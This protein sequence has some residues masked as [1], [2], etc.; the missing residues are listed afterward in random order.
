MK[1]P[2]YQNK[3]IMIKSIIVKCFDG[4]EINYQCNHDGLFYDSDDSINKLSTR[5]ILPPQSEPYYNKVHVNDLLNEF[6]FFRS[7]IS[8][9]CGAFAFDHNDIKVRKC[10]VQESIKHAI[11]MQSKLSEKKK[12]RLKK[13]IAEALSILIE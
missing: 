8:N 2:K 7:R 10:T 13:A 11:E 4:T 6:R 5:A 9:D 12:T 3:N 1:W